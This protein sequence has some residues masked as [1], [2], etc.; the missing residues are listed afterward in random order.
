MPFINWTGKNVHL[1]EIFMKRLIKFKEGGRNRSD[2]M[3]KDK[4]TQAMQQK[5]LFKHLTLF[6]FDVVF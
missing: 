3:V 4:G 5:D 1:N 6:S 2:E